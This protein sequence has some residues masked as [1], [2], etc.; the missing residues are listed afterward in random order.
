LAVIKS[1]R[2]EGR[3]NQV[4]VT[5]IRIVIPPPKKHSLEKCI[6]FVDIL[7]DPLTRLKSAEKAAI[8]DSADRMRRSR[9]ESSED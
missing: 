5:I 8:R 1:R 6:A 7:H 9:T 3:G 2:R 4:L